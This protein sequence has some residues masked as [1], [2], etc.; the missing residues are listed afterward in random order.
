MS[1]VHAPHRALA[2]DSQHSSSQSELQFLVRCSALGRPCASA[3][4]DDDWLSDKSN[5]A[6]YEVFAKYEG[7]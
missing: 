4:V 5:Q 6:P 3:K 1:V 2:V 7:D